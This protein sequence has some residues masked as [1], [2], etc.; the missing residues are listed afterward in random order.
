MVISIV[1]QSQVA[2]DR[3]KTELQRANVDAGKVDPAVQSFKNTPLI[4]N[5]EEQLV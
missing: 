2:I 1:L 3:N 4:F 5:H